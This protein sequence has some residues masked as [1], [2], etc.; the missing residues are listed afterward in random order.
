[1]SNTFLDIIKQKETNLVLSLDVSNKKHFFRILTDCAPYICALKLHLELYSFL[2]G[3]TLNKLIQCSKKYNFIIIE[4]RKFADIGNTQYLQANE[5]IKKGI[6]HFTS[7]LFTGKD[8]LYAFPAEANIFLISDMSCRNAFF[9][10]KIDLRSIIHNKSI[11]YYKTIPQ[12]IGFVSQYNIN[13]NNNAIILRPGIRL[14]ANV[15]NQKQD[16]MGQKYKLPQIIPNVCWVVGRDIYQSDN[17]K[18]MAKQYQELFKKNKNKWFR[19][20]KLTS[21]TSIL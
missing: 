8:A 16:T 14:N 3:K 2:K 6:T 11:D 10:D 13:K 7:H 18:N 4:D 5:F 15:I 20:T 1:M 21:L 19:K 9:S 12:V 17:P